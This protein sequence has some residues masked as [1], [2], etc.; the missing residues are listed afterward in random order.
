MRVAVILFP[1]TNC[2]NETKRA[3]ESAGME[4][5]IVRW[6]RPQGLEKYQGYVLPGGFSYEDRVRAGVIA[7][8]DPVMETIR[9]EAEK[10]KPVLGICNGAQVLIETGMVPGFSREVEMALAP[11]INP[12]AKGYYCT[13]VRVRNFSKKCI[14]TRN[15]KEI[16][17]IPIAHAEGRFAT[18]KRV[19]DRLLE[20]GQVVFRYC[21][22]KGEPTPESNPNGSVDNI[23]GVCNPQGNVLAM[24]PHPERANWARQIPGFEAREG[25]DSPGPCRKIFESMRRYMESCK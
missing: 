18:E 8:T 24:M 20:N 5:D 2:E 13:W 3:L 14:F 23:A 22:G 17:P 4:A 1:G 11:N 7:A 19:L 16:L 10:G 12:R 6:N 25:M 21:N 15:L 9:Q